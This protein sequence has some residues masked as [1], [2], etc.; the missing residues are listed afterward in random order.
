MIKYE[1]ECVGCSS[2][3]L[4]CLGTSCINRNVP[5]WYCDE[6]GDEDELY[7]F[8]GQELCI[9]CIAGKLEKVTA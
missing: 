9:N 2:L 3:G 8:E 1:D 6:C 4:P 7:E 5:H